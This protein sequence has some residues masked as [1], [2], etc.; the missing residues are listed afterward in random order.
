MVKLN[1]EYNYDEE[2]YSPLSWGIKARRKEFSDS[3]ERGVMPMEIGINVVYLVGICAILIAVAI[4]AFAKNK[5]HI[6]INYKEFNV[7]IEV[8]QKSK[9]D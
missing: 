1:I 2:H 6:I 9:K 3:N 5:L 8:G 4:L 7:D